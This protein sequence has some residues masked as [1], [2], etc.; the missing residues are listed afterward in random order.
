MRCTFVVLA[1]AAVTVA[2]HIGAQPVVAQDDVQQACE[3]RLQGKAD[4]AYQQLKQHVSRE[5]EDAGAWFELARTEFYLMQ[6]D[7][8]QR[9]VARAIE[10]DADNARFHRLAGVLAAYNAVSKYKSPDTRA[11]VSALMG[12]SLREFEQAVANDPQLL[13]ARV[14]LVNA[15]IQ[16]PAE[17][18]GDREKATQQVEQLEKL[19]AVA[20]TEAAL[21]ADRGP[22]ASASLCGRR[23]S[24]SIPTMPQRGPDS[25][26]L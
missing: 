20:G 8:A 22:R 19:S 15:Y 13:E 18:G 26:E 10:L 14:A 9:S 25:R 21:P 17:Q 2:G 4:A 3:L 5:A 7:E 24:I 6:L 23:R 11:Q 1:I 12:E 16:T